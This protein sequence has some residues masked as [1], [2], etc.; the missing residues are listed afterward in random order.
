[1]TYRTFIG[2][3]TVKSVSLIYQYGVTRKR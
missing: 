3:H 1:M 2:G